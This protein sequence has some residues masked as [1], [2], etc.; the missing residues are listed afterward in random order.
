MTRDEYIEKVNYFFD[1]G[2]TKPEI[3]NKM[4]SEALYTLNEL[5][6]WPNDVTVDEEQLFRCWCV[7]EKLKQKNFPKDL[8][9]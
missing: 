6:L 2:V 1:T 5:D 4:L 7:V 3:D 9:M 8:W